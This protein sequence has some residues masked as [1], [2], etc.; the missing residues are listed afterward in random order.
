MSIVVRQ[1][2]EEW[3]IDLKSVMVWLMLSRSEL[4]MMEV[5]LVTGGGLFVRREVISE[6]S[7]SSASESIEGYSTIFSFADRS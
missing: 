6:S 4:L 2:V 5:L 7:G 3:M 1:K